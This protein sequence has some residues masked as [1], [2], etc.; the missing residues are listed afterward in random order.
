[1]HCCV[2]CPGSLKLMDLIF[3]KQVP[4]NTQATKHTCLTA[5]STTVLPSGFQQYP[6][7]NMVEMGQCINVFVL[8]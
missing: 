4:V 3:E 2:E 1:M 6:L 5:V 7:G 8:N